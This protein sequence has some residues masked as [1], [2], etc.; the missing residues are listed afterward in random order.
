MLCVILLKH[1]A[2]NTEYQHA[3]YYTGDICVRACVCVCVYVCG[4]YMPPLCRGRA[5]VSRQWCS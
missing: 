5:P 4:G 1:L 3:I 2:K